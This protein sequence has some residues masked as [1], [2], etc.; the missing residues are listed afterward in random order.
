MNIKHNFSSNL[1]N[2]INSSIY[3]IFDLDT[4]KEKLAFM[5]GVPLRTTA[6]NYLATVQ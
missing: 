4:F 2:L 6:S 5:W 1:F 3:L